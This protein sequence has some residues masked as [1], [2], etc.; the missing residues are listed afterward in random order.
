MVPRAR[1]ESGLRG[2]VG[3]DL[4]HVEGGV[5]ELGGLRREVAKA[6]VRDVGRRVAGPLELDGRIV[7]LERLH[8]RGAG[9]GWG[10]SGGGRA[11]WRRCE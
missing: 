3:D 5:G 6:D 8:S 2:T 1:H 7:H 9:V 11:G 10:W 4:R